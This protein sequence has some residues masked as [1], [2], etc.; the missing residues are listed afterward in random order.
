ME[1]LFKTHQKNDNQIKISFIIPVYN[2]SKY[3]RQCLQSILQQT[4][5][6]I[7]LILVNDGSTDESPSIC[8]EFEKRD[9]RVLTIHTNNNGLGMARNTGLCHAK[10]DY[11]IF[12][13]SDDFWR[14][15]DS[16]QIIV[17][18]ITDNPRI[19]LLFFNVV[20]FND[21]TKEEHK[22]KHF[23]NDSN[24][25]Y[26]CDDAFRLLVKSGNIPM[27]A[28]SKVIKK[29]ILI[30]KQIKFP[31][32]IYGE[33]IPWFIDL[34]EIVNNVYFL[35]NYVYA[36]R[37]NVSNSI[38]NNNKPKHV[39]DMKNII[40]NEIKK[41]PSRSY[42]DDGKRCV[43]AFL[44]YNY[45]ILLSQYDY[46]KKQEQTD[47]WEFI[48]KYSSLL[49]NIIHPKVYKVHI[50]TC[51]LGLKNTCKILNLYKNIIKKISK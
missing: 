44:A 37:Q 11:I 8:N 5:T 6:N 14:N 25:I 28:W 40:E 36:Y 31:S 32:G 33:D 18:I 2:V 1:R 20:Y 15:I 38:T 7:E 42:S 48:N 21:K 26:S 47:F 17:D 50:L 35:N 43:E 4:Y 16:L 12:V 41:L 27:S 29:S 3:L 23:P 22:W 45:C 39:E 9:N 13:D 24:N 19:D 30:E 49:N 34:M 51:F 10:G 46:I